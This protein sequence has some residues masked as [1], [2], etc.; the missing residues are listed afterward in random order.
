MEGKLSPSGGME[1]NG[2]CHPN[3]GASGRGQA[4]ALS[5]GSE[6]WRRAG[7]LITRKAA[8]SPSQGLQVPS[9]KDEVSPCPPPR[10]P[11]SH[12][13]YCKVKAWNG[14]QGKGHG[15]PLK[16]NEVK[17]GPVTIASQ[18]STPTLGDIKQ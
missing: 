13:V 9:S 6:G 2:L 18:P 1:V 3:G 8:V 5:A 10:T 16:V 4:E 14:E 12:T 11:W 15:M 17:D 7:S